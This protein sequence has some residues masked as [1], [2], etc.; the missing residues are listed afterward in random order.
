MKT[1]IR[2]FKNYDKNIV[3]RDIIIISDLDGHYTLTLWSAWFILHHLFNCS[4]S[5]HGLYDVIS[6][7]LLLF[8]L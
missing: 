7:G 4:W 1:L 6:L 2:M 8:L 3:L 5:G